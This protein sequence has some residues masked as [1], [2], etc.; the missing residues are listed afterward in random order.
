MPRR[1]WRERAPLLAMRAGCVVG[2]VG[3][4]AGQAAGGATP[5]QVVFTGVLALAFVAVILG[6]VRGT[7]NRLARTGIAR[8][9]SRQPWGM[10]GIG[11]WFLSIMMWLM[12]IF[13]VVLVV[14]RPGLPQ[15]VWNVVAYVGVAVC[16]TGAAAL[17]ARMR[18]EFDQQYSTR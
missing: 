6:V 10:I 17:I 16:C 9:P 15:H 8:V 13:G 3:M 2:A 12:A 1:D 14:Q 4:V 7:E 18:R 5:G 11:L